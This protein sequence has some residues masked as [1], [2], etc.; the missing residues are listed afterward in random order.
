MKKLFFLIVTMIFWGSVQA[1]GIME[2]PIPGIDTLKIKPELKPEFD[3]SGSLMM[4]PLSVP[5]FSRPIT[6]DSPLFD[7]SPAINSKW[8]VYDK[9]LDFYPSL[10]PRF[11][12]IGNGG[13]VPLFIHS[14]TVFNQATYQVSNKLMVGGNSFGANSVFTPPMTRPGANQWEIRGASMFME[15]KVSKNFSIGA[16]ISVQGKSTLH[17]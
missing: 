6:I 10:S 8:T 1:Q 2:A 17:P 5:L 9:N 16:Q 4:P 12:T 7:F 13:F 11:S 15:Y 3:L 14:G